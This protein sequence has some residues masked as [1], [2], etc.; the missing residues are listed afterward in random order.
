MNQGWV[1]HDVFALR[2]SVGVHLKHDSF[3][4]RIYFNG[5]DSYGSFGFKYHDDE[6]LDNYVT[7]QH[8]TEPVENLTIKHMIEV[9]GF[10]VEDIRG[11]DIRVLIKMN[12]EW[13]GWGNAGGN[14]T[15]GISWTEASRAYQAVTIDGVSYDKA[16]DPRTDIVDYR[17]TQNYTGPI[18]LDGLNKFLTDN[19][20]SVINISTGYDITMYT[21]EGKFY[22]HR[23][24]INDGQKYPRL[25]S[26]VKVPQEE[27]P[28]ESPYMDLNY[29]GDSV[30]RAPTG[31]DGIG[32][33]KDVHGTFIKF[34]HYGSQG[35]F[36]MSTQTEYPT[37]K[38]A[39]APA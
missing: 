7:T 39:P 8:K 1:G 4:D 32:F 17:G 9:L 5:S 23:N 38:T 12:G 19:P 37:V 3:K 26:G 24:Q 34:Y 27:N 2:D 36:L 33:L 14:K 28:K 21:P 22:F 35:L 6:W 25:Y 16:P 31:Y 11:M 10:V 13:F 18:K 30:G 20:G 29:I 15:L